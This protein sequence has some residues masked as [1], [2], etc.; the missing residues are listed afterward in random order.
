C[1]GSA[2][3]HQHPAHRLRTPLAEA[4]IVLPRAALVGVTLEAHL[5]V[6]IRRKV[7]TVRGEH[8]VVLRRHVAAIEIEIDDPLLQE[9]LA[10]V[11]IV[12]EDT[13]SAPFAE[14]ARRRA[15]RA[16][17]RGAARARLEIGQRVRAIPAPGDGDRPKKTCQHDAGSHHYFDSDMSNYDL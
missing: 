1:C 4:D 16:A 9:T 3:Q 2:L 10:A 11:E 5:D 7:L 13:D 12:L 14:R 8:L 15:R 17:A 6:R